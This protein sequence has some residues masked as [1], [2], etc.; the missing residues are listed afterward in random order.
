[1]SATMSYPLPFLL[2]EYG[3]IKFRIDRRHPRRLRRFYDLMEAILRFLHPG[4]VFKPHT[5]PSELI[6]LT[7]ETWGK[8]LKRKISEQEAVEII[9][10]FS[11]LLSLLKEVRRNGK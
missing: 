8:R 11:N 7:Q 1:M 6:S 9:R 5:Y 2:Y 3:L 10:H 4:R